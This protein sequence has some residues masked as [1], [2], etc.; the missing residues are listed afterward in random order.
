MQITLNTNELSELDLKALHALTGSEFKEGV[1]EVDDERVAELEQLLED[2]KKELTATK[3]A[4]TKA[5]NKLEE[6]S[7]APAIELNVMDIPEVQEKLAELQ[8]QID[9]G[10]SDDGILKATK[11]KLEKAEKL[12]EKME[13]TAKARTT[14]LAHASEK[15]H[16]LEQELAQ[17]KEEASKWERT[18]AESVD[19]TPTIEPE[20]T[21][22]TATNIEPSEPDVQPDDKDDS[23]VERLEEMVTDVPS[24][25]R[26]MKVFMADKNLQMQ[27]VQPVDLDL[28]NLLSKTLAGIESKEEAYEVAAKVLLVQK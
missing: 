11:T 15:I 19:A 16:E 7:K 17:I 2:T 14:E 23:S 3:S 8:A 18:V 26:F 6:L 5:E 20:S 21:G 13:E 4:K 10:G 22:G 1:L 27:D 9:A 28:L 24:A 25:G 12:A